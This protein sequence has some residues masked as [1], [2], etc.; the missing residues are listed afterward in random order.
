MKALKLILLFVVMLACVVGGFFIFNGG[1]GE[2]ELPPIDENTF[3]EYSQEFENDWKGVGDWDEA[4]FTRHHMTIQQLSTEYSVE[5]LRNFD[6]RIVTEIVAQKIFAEWKNANCDKNVINIYINAVKTICDYEGEAAKNDPDIQQIN[7]VNT[8]Y[9]SALELAG[10]KIGL[11]PTFNGSTWNSYTDYSNKIQKQKKDIINNENYKEYLHNITAINSRFSKIDGELKEGRNTFYQSLGDKIY[12][13]YNKIS[14]SK[15][16][17]NQLIQLRKARDK[18]E[19]EYGSNSKINSLAKKFASDVS[20]NE[21]RAAEEA[22]K[23]ANDL[24]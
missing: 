19:K 23:Q 6:R 4:T 11:T 3:A 20:D 12:A 18:Y 5:Q 17:N 14:S 9:K 2:P 1:T 13:Y 24:R 22:A 15:R 7:K 10:K 21:A 8:T 16:T